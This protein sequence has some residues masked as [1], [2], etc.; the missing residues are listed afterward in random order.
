MGKSI[1][2]GG[3]AIAMFDDRRL[4]S[5]R[6]GCCTTNFLTAI[7]QWICFL[8]DTIFDITKINQ[9]LQLDMFFY[10]YLIEYVYIT[11]LNIILYYIW[12]CPNMWLS[13]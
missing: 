2:N 5:S 7:S 11:K 4:L 1:I 13:K 9:I 3:L 10:E 12:I 8:W 6:M